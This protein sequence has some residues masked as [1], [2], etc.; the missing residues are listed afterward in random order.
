MPTI[1]GGP[2][3]GRRWIPGVVDRDAMARTAAAA[4]V[5]PCRTV[6]IPSDAAP[7]FYRR[8]ALF[9]DVVNRKHK[10]AA[11]RAA[12]LIYLLEKLERAMR[13][14]LTTLTLATD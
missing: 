1:E 4:Q 8:A 13:F 12:Y 3:S 11:H 6:E 14:E 7:A 9:G 2:N 5:V 10:K